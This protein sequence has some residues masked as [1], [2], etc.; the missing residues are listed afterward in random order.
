MKKEKNYGNCVNK[1][2]CILSKGISYEQYLS[3]RGLL[4]GYAEVF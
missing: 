1:S 4:L 3:G 2:D